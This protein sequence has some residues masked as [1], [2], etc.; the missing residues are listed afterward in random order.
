MLQLETMPVVAGHLQNVEDLVRVV[1]REVASAVEAMKG[2]A[3]TFEAAW[4]RMVQD[5]A[6][7]QMTEVHAARPRLLRAFEQR[8]ALLHETH[9][10]GRWLRD[11]GRVD[12]PGPDALLPE[13]AGL[14]QLKARILDRW[15][16]ADDLEDLAARDYPL[17]AADL[18]G[19]GPRRRPP[20]GY[21]AETSKPF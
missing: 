20:A 1:A 3:A 2:S 18:D 21:Y 5:V 11:R 14:E 17:T 7:G 4:R 13:I 15:Q 19:L 16:T 8:L 6:R 9:I 12:G 10:L